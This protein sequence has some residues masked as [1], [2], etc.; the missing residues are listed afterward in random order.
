MGK[1][2]SNTWAYMGHFHTNHHVKF[3]LMSFLDPT[4]KSFFSSMLLPLGSLPVSSSWKSIPHSQDWFSP[5]ICLSAYVLF[6]LYCDDMDWTYLSR[7]LML[8]YVWWW[9]PVIPT[10]KRVRHEHGKFKTTLDY[11]IRPYL[12]IPRAEDTGQWHRDCQSCLS[13]MSNSAPDLTGDSEGM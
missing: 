7:I 10:V 3:V 6:F 11:L 5:L 13:T 2:C 4:F 12:K 9:M 8:S 1:K